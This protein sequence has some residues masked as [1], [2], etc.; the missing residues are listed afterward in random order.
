MN[1]DV[2]HDS[3]IVRVRDVFENVV[4]QKSVK[5]S[6]RTGAELPYLFFR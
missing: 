1:N 5:D 2:L 6:H 4:Y 3:E